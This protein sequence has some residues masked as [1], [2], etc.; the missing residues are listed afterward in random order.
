MCVCAHVCAP[1]RKHPFPHCDQVQKYGGKRRQTGHFCCVENGELW[2]WN[3]EQPQVCWACGNG[4]RGAGI[5]FT[6]ECRGSPRGI[7][8]DHSAR[9]CCPQPSTTRRWTI[10][11]WR[12]AVARQPRISLKKAKK[13]SRRPLETSLVCIA[14][15]GSGSSAREPLLPSPDPLS[16]LPCRDR[17]E[18]RW[19][20]FASCGASDAPFVFHAF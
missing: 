2:R 14:P 11:R 4:G 15:F 13:T 20:C 19:S 8:P 17:T 12:L 1:V 9:I 3:A 7:P 10:N 5:C 16:S 6:F 18:G